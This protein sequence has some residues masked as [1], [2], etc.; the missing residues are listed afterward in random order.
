MLSLRVIL[1]LT[2]IIHAV[3]SMSFEVIDRKPVLEPSKCQ[4]SNDIV[5]MVHSKFDHFGHRETIRKTWGRDQSLD[6]VNPKV[7]RVFVLA[8]S[9]LD[10]TP[11]DMKPFE[12]E[13]ERNGDILFLDLQDAYRNLT[14]KHPSG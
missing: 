12:A 4:K 3:S 5:I 10:M 8:K 6:E 1:L 2:T 7:K 11:E 13:A 14:Y 9:D